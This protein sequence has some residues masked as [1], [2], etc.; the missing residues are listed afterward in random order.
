M[1]EKKIVGATTV[2][3][4]A[5][6]VFQ[7]DSGIDSGIS[8]SLD[9]I[10][11]TVKTI[12]NFLDTLPDGKLLTRYRLSGDINCS[13][14]TFDSWAAYP[15]LKEYRIKVSYQGCVQVLWGNKNTILAYREGLNVK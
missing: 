4:K 13:V 11:K 6:M 10:P 1:K 7:V 15:M 3:E 8:L 9:K 14:S 12:M 5:K 2:K